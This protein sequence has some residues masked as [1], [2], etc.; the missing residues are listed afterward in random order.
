[1]KFF[2]FYHFDIVD[3]F[4]GDSFFAFLKSLICIV[5]EFVIYDDEVSFLPDWKEAWGTF[6]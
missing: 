3:I 6:F 2:M 4:D 5:T 1:M